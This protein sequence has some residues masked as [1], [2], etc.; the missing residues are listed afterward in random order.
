MLTWNGNKRS[1]EIGTETNVDNDLVIPKIGAM[2]EDGNSLVQFYPSALSFQGQ[3]FQQLD[4]NTIRPIRDVSLQTFIAN[5]STVWVENWPTNGDPPYLTNLTGL[6]PVHFVFDFGGMSGLDQ[7]WQWMMTYEGTDSITSFYDIS[8]AE[9]SLVVEFP[10]RVLSEP[11]VH[12]TRL[13][14]D[15]TNFDIVFTWPTESLDAMVVLHDDNAQPDTIEWVESYLP[16]SLAYTPRVMEDDSP[17]LYGI[18]PITGNTYKLYHQAGDRC[19]ERRD[20]DSQVPPRLLN[21]TEY[22]KTNLLDADFV[23]WVE[24]ING[25]DVIKWLRLQYQF[26]YDEPIVNSG[27]LTVSGSVNRLRAQYSEDVDYDGPFD[28]WYVI[29]SE[30]DDLSDVTYLRSMMVDRN[31]I[32]TDDYDGYVVQPVTSRLLAAYPN[33]F[34]ASTLIPFG[35]NR[36]GQVRITVFDLLGRQVGTIGEGH[37]SAGHHQVSWQP[38]RSLASG[39]YLVRMDADKYQQTQRVQLVK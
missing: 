19:I 4:A 12:E 22:Q 3:V 18:V 9:P 6:P 17:T 2:S 24:R 31:P 26:G 30:Y 20:I 21:S 34:N 1:W 14:N 5:D 35:L 7:R 38:N 29:W 23:T 28:A 10:G 8:Y 25:L 11:A 36:A 27:D 16:S 32:L 33:P 39:T 37:Y 13:N 15:A